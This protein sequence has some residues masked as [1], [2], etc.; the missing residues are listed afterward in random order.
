MRTKT[1][2]ALKELFSSLGGNIAD[3]TNIN[4]IPDMIN[5][6]STLDISSG[7]G[8]SGG[9]SSDDADIVNALKDI[10]VADGGNE[11]DVANVSKI[12]DMLLSITYLLE[13]DNAIEVLPVDGETEVYNTQIKDF[14]IDCFIYDHI[15]LGYWDEVENGLTD[16]GPLSETGYYLAVRIINS[17]YHGEIEVGIELNGETT[18]YEPVE[19]ENYIILKIENYAYNQF[20][21]INVTQGYIHKTLKYAIYSR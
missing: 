14:Q 19:D 6:L 4:N 8:D 13:M 15:I 3:V 20:L 1:V 9:E 7:G 12:S 5:A 2:N 18:I 11:E 17:T 16:S 10:Y 21:V